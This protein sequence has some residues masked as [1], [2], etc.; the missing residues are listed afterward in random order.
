[1]WPYSFQSD[2]YGPEYVCA[3]HFVATGCC[4][5]LL[6]HKKAV[7]IFNYDGCTAVE[8]FVLYSNVENK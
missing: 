8:T 6:F 3:K 1:M 5:L 2:S 7:F 4:F